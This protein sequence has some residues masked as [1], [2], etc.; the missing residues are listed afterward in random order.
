MTSLKRMKGLA[1][2]RP[3]VYGNVASPL[4]KKPADSNHT[5]RWTVSVR[6]VNN[7]DISYFVKK[8]SFK[9]HDTYENPNRVV[10]KPPFEVTETG[11]GEF[12]IIIK[13]HFQPASGEKPLTLYHHLKLHPYEED[14]TIAPSPKQRPVSSFNYDEIVFN[15]PIEA[16][17]NI[18]QEHQ[19]HTLPLKKTPNHPF[20]V[21][22]E[23][24]ELEKIEKGIK[25]T[26]Q[27][28]ARYRD[29]CKRLEAEVS[30][31]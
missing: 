21:Q 13:I 5:H 15:E 28:I 17:Y 22:A 4:G 1:V 18:L 8:V 2:F 26:L 12:D 23:Q 20:S 14:G 25:S 30:G 7:E 10:E 19:T 16:F 31:K 3:I 6:G 29:R 9:L 27:E 11:W 24:E